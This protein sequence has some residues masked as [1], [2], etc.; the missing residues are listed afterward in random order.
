[1]MRKLFFIVLV[2][3]S[4]LVQAQNVQNYFFGYKL[5]SKI[6]VEKIDKTMVTEYSRSLTYVNENPLLIGT[7]NDINYVGCKWDDTNIII[8]KPDMK[9]LGVEFIETGDIT[10]PLKG[11]YDELLKTL[12]EKYGAPESVGTNTR[13]WTGKNGIT[14]ELDYTIEFP[15]PADEEKALKESGAEVPFSHVYLS[16]WD[17]KTMDRAKQYNKDQL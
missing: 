3:A 15:L 9:L 10:V 12:T 11:R 16:Y 8:F 1:M 2:F 17:T 6:T 13:R 5:G 14:V 4:A 7:A